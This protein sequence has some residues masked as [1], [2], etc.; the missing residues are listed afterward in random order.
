[1]TYELISRIGGIVLGVLILSSAALAQPALWRLS[2][3]DSD[4]YLFGTMHILP[5]DLDW[6]SDE[7][8]AAF[9]AAGTVWFEAPVGDPQM[10]AASAMLMIQHGFNPAGTTL[11]A[12][13]SDEAR[14]KLNEI[15][16]QYG[17]S[18]A[19]LEGMRPWMAATVLQLAFIQSQGFNPESGVESVLWPDAAEAGK[20]LAFFETIEEQIRFLADLPPEVEAAY[21]EDAL[22]EFESGTEDLDEMLQ[23]WST[24]NV[25]ALDAITNEEMRESAPDLH[26]SLIVDRNRRWLEPIREALAGT[27]THFIAVG[28]GHLTGPDGLPELLRAEGLTVTGP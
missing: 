17:L 21:L 16:G 27:G 4:I 10:Q 9:N 11:S 3:A 18:G 23:A 20:E 25:E 2:D 6:R 26:Q 8:E 19:D 24:G 13:L 5:S 15:V 28:A 14:A 22:L 7:I 12:Q 1:M